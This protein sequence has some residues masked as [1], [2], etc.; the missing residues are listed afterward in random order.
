MT[1][2]EWVT[3][4]DAAELT[5]RS[6]RRIYDL[7]SPI[8]HRESTAGSQV[9]LPSARAHFATPRPGRPRRHAAPPS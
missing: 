5:D 7:L 8:P 4:A 9:H 1:D 3:V 2:P 6:K